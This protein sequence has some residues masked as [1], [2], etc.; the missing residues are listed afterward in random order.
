VNWRIYRLPGSRG[1]WHID[2]GPGTQIFNVRGYHAA[3][4]YS[5]DIGGEHIP[6]A[7]IQIDEQELHIVNG[8][9]IFEFLGVAESVREVLQTIKEN[10]K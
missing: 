6:R 2:S 10:Q 3:D 5:K 8:E 1:V 4:S 9:A 7:W